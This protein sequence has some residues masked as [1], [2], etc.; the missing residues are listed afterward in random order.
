MQHFYLADDAHD[1]V[2]L[3]RRRYREDLEMFGYTFPNR[4]LG[5]YAGRHRP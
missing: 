5:V 2:E 3:V 1:L 4:S